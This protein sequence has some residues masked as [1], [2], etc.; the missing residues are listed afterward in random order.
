[1]PLPIPNAP[2]ED[3]S[4][5]FIL[6]LLRT[7]KSFDSIFVV[8]DHFSKMAHFIPCRK[9]SD[10]NYIAQLFSREIV[11]LHGLPRTIVSNLDNK[12]LSHF[13][14]T[15]WKRLDKT[16]QFSSTCHSQIDGQIEV[17][18]HTLGNI[19][20]CLVKEN[21]KQ[22]ENV[23]PQAKFAYN[24]VPNHSS[25]KSPF[26]VV[27]IC[28]PLHTLDLV[29]LPKLL[30]MSIIVDHLINKM[31]DV[32]EEVKKKLEESTAK[33][34]AIADKHKRL[35]SYKVGDYVMVHL[36]KEGVPTREY[37]KLKHK[38][39]GPFHILQKINDNVYIID[40]PEHYVIL[41]TFNVQDLYEYHGP[42]RIL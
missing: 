28:P 4:M 34:K 33:Y 31:I 5:D 7:Q 8:V 25:G 36:R 19:L 22:W 18:N 10:A 16:L 24:N 40:L 3:I 26:E 30:G 35:K 29:P 9:T 17:T 14:H 32:Y 15:L 39:I 12:F 13:W 41:N 20:Q 21:P 38:K 2:W 6:G 1:M 37:S 42:E 23:L 11:R 27:Y